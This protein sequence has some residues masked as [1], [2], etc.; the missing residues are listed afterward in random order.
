[1]VY[2]IDDAYLFTGDTIW[3]GMDGGYSFINKLAED[4][5]LALKSLGIL[6][7]KLRDKGITPK[8]ITG[9]TGWTNDLDFAFAHRK[10]I[11]NPSKKVKVHDPE[12]PYDAYDEA[13]DTE[14]KAISYFSTK[15]R[16]S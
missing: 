15:R 5:K 6:E 2:L 12:A 9:H 7:N 3:F 1:M 16:K 8:I 10:E 13:D 14:E 4:N 11:C